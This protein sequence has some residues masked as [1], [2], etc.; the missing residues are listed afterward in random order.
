M[1]TKLQIVLIFS[2]ILLHFLILIVAGP[3]EKP[4]STRLKSIE[5]INFDNK[6]TTI[7]FCYV[8]AY[9][10]KFVTLN[11]KFKLFRKFEKPLY[12]QYVLSRKSSGNFCQNIYKSDL[13]EFCG[14]MDGADVNPF[15]KSV[16]NILNST[17]PQL[18]H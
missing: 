14:I 3:P 6:T 15:V 10:R 16:I 11:V 1:K 2:V 7:E 8:R 4:N 17:A 9:S 12:I 5:C 13:I 18:F